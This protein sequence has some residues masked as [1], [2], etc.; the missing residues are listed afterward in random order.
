MSEQTTLP[1]GT[2]VDRF[3]KEEGLSD[4]AIAIMKTLY[5]AFE[6]LKECAADQG[7]NKVQLIDAAETARRRGWIR[8]IY[9]KTDETFRIEA[10]ARGES[11]N[12]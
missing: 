10:T 9:D 8:I 1:I 11:A 2:L 3:G 4:D 5:L 12:A 6:P 7:W